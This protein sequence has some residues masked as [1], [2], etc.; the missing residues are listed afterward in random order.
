MPEF[1]SYPTSNSLNPF[2]K[3]LNGYLSERGWHEAKQSIWASLTKIYRF[4]KR[5]DVI[6]FHW[7]EAFWRSTSAVTYT[8][9]A[10]RFI[11]ITAFM[12]QCGYKIVFSLHNLYPHYG[13]GNMHFL[14]YFMRVYMLKMS[15]LLVG[16]SINALDDFEKFYRLPIGHKYVLALHGCYE[17]YLSE[18]PKIKRDSRL[19][20]FKANGRI[21]LFLRYSQN[22][23]KGVRFFLD[24]YCEAAA[25]SE[26]TLIIGGRPSA[27]EIQKL[28]E[29]NVHYLVIDES[30]HEIPGFLSEKTLVECLTACDFVVL[31]YQE[32]TCSG[33]FFLALTFLRPVLAPDLNFFKLHTDEQTAVLFETGNGD[34]IRETLVTLSDRSK[35]ISRQALA[36][37]RG[38]YSWKQSAADIAM[39]YE[40]VTGNAE[41][42]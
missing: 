37:R 17:N 18:Q 21:K 24:H 39:A 31:P 42:Q 33:M 36:E 27:A 9:K 25:R 15:N 2:V 10:I 5:I 30:A 6:H 40:S 41:I 13:K 7:P 8:V 20:S 16:H 4:R 35:R 32:I 1:I 28:E 3:I 38:K 34:A 22:D 26:L 19:E 23:Y 12:R 11:F 29:S 14:E